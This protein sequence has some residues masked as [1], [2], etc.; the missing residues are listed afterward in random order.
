[1]I[2]TMIHTDSVR[3]LCHANSINNNCDLLYYFVDD[4][5]IPEKKSFQQSKGS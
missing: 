3:M 4:K 2:V 1:M 5:F